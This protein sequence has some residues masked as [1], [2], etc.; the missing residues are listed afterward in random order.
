MAILAVS[1][2]LKGSKVSTTTKVSATS[3]FAGTPETQSSLKHTSTKQNSSN[4]LSGS[5]FGNS[6]FAYVISR[7]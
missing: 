2:S 3:S 4:L 1:K 7:S 6:A 5:H